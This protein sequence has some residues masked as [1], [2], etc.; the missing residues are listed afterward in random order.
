MGQDGLLPRRN[1]SA[2]ADLGIDLKDWHAALK[3]SVISHKFLQNPPLQSRVQLRGINSFKFNYPPVDNFNPSKLTSEMLIELVNKTDWHLR[4]LVISL[5]E[6]L[7]RDQQS[8]LIEQARL[9][10][11][12][13]WRK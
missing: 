3:K 4:Q 6:K 2:L 13:N 7:N 5:E 11:K 10:G 9:K 12:I 1:G 8:Y